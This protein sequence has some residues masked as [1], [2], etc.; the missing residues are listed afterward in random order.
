MKKSNILLSYLLAGGI[1]AGASAG[2]MGGIKIYSENNELGVYDIDVQSDEKVDIKDDQLVYANFKNAQGQTVAAF[3]NLKDP[4]TILLDPKVKSEKRRFNEVEFADW[5]ADNYNRQTPIFELKIGSMRFVNEY[6]DSLLPSE[7]I[8]YAQW[9]NKNV[10]WGPDAITL[11]H[12]ALKKGVTRSGNNL[13]LGQHATERKEVTKIEFY[14]DSFFGSF[15]IY[16]ALTG[17]GNSDDN[18]TYKIFHNPISKESLDK[19]F[20]SIPTQQVLANYDKSK[21]SAGI[22]AID[23]VENEDI[24]FYDLVK[25]LKKSFPQNK[26]IQDKLA[27]ITNEENFFVFAD[28]KQNLDQVKKKFELAILMLADEKDIQLPQ[29]LQLIFPEDFTK[30]RKIKWIRSALSPFNQQIKHDANNIPQG[31]FLLKLE[32]LM[33]ENPS[34]QPKDLQNQAQ[35]PTQTSDQRKKPQVQ[36]PNQSQAQTKDFRFSIN[37]QMKANRVALIVGELTTKIHQKAEKIAKEGFFDLYNIN[38]PVGKIIAIYQNSPEN[39]LFLPVDSKNPAL[40]AENEFITQFDASKFSTYEIKTAKKLSNYKLEIELVDQK[41]KKSIKKIIFDLDPKGKN[42]QSQ[43]EEFSSFK[44]A[45]DWKNRAIPRVIQEIETL[46]DGKSTTVYQLYAEVFDGLIDKVL[47]HRKTNGEKLVGTYIISEV[48]PKTGLKTY[49]TKQGSFI[50][51]SQSSRIP[52][53]S[54]LKASSPFFKTT[55][56]NYLKYVGAHEYGHHQTLN[57]AQ[58]IS[59]PDSSIILDAIST[60]TG[61]GLQSFYNLDVLRKYLHARSSGLDLRKAGPSLEAQKNGIYPNFTFNRDNKFESEVDIYGSNEN[62]EVDSL[63]T[64][65]SRRFLQTIDGLKTAADLRKLKLYDLF[66]LNSIDPESA[67]INP[68]I[69]DS[70]KFFRNDWQTI[71]DQSKKGFINSTESKSLFGNSLTDAAGNLLE[72][73]EKGKLIVAEFKESQ[74]KRTFSDL[75]VKVFFANGRP[76][77]D[78]TIFTKPNS[79]SELKAKIAEIQKAFSDNVV[80]NFD[81]NGWDTKAEGFSRFLPSNPFFAKSLSAILANNAEKEAFYGTKIADNPSKLEI[82]VELPSSVFD[83]SQILSIVKRYIKDEEAIKLGE[84]LVQ[85][86]KGKLDFPTFLS[87]LNKEELTNGNSSAINKLFEKI[88][89][90]PITEKKDLYI[91]LRNITYFR[92]S[93]VGKIDLAVEFIQNI[94]NI[95][96]EWL[97]NQSLGINQVLNTPKPNTTPDRKALVLKSYWNFVV[98]DQ[99]W[100]NLDKIFIIKG[101]KN[102]DKIPSRFFSAIRNFHRLTPNVYDKNFVNLTQGAVFASSHLGKLI[103]INGNEYYQN[104]KYDFLATVTSGGKNYLVLDHSEFDVKIRSLMRRWISP[105]G[106]LLK[107]DKVLLEDKNTNPKLNPFFGIA[108]D[109]KFKIGPDQKIDTSKIYLDAWD[110]TLF[111]FDYN[112]NYFGFQNEQKETVF[113]SIS[114]FIEFISID[115][116][117]LRVTKNGED[118]IRNWSLD[119]VNS[120]FDLYRYAFDR[121]QKEKFVL[122]SSTNNQLTWKKE[123]KS[124]EIIGK[125][126]ANFEISSEKLLENLQKY[127]NFLMEAFDKSTLNL[128]LKNSKIENKNIDPLFLSSIGFMGFKNYARKVD[129]NS[130]PATKFGKLTNLDRIKTPETTWLTFSTFLKENSLVFDNEDFV[131]DDLNN[132]NKSLVYKWILNFLEDKKIEFKDLDL[133]RLQYLVGTKTFADYTQEDGLI[134]QIQRMDVDLGLSWLRSKNLARF[135]TRADDFFSNYVY[136]FPESLTRDFVQIHYSPSTEELDNISPLFKKMTEA[137][138]GNEYFVDGIYTRKWIKNF[139]PAFDISQ[140]YAQNL[141]SRFSNFFLTSFVITR[142]NENLEKLYQNLLKAFK[143]AQSKNLYQKFNDLSS[144]QEAEIKK[145]IGSQE[146]P[147]KFIDKVLQEIENVDKISEI[148]SKIN[149]QKAD[150]FSELTIEVNR[151]MQDYQ[152]E[153]GNYKN[154]HNLNIQP[155]VGNKTWINGYINKNVL[156]NNGFFKDRFQRK[157][158]NWE[159]YDDNLESVKDPNIRITNLNGEKVDNRAEAFW[160][161]SLKTQGVG[162]RSVSGIWRDSKHDKV[163]FWGFLKSQDANKAHFL[164]LEDE[165]TGQRFY[166]QLATKGTNNIFYLKKQADLSSKWTLENEGYKSWVSAWS[167]I[168]EFKNALLRP[169]VSGIKRFRIYF[170]DQKRQEIKGLFTLG[171]TKFIAEN[172][173]NYQTA[174]TYIEK[175]AKGDYLV[176]RPQF[177]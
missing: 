132:S 121:L 137:N 47:N 130:L 22:P 75:K 98:S 18:L 170:S 40:E 25:I 136:S 66:L 79:L 138:T 37:Q 91:D 3:E 86:S 31:V 90:T 62:D 99:I 97:Q 55:G 165:S 148:S 126:L 77:I 36:Q 6:W 7:F 128:L 115:P 34:E 143:N 20:E 10:A 120:K 48:D 147:S 57:Y 117:A 2:I 122:K 93:L 150:L 152:G 139:I 154:Y 39:R 153:L 95:Y 88:F 151:I 106:N 54:L 71:E 28:P 51:Y 1:L 159:L 74:D 68:S 113:S 52:Y 109:F 65:K 94:Y 169:G 23:L 149:R 163:A 101:E 21:V 33:S 123:L 172:G 135:E 80:S 102:P 144:Q 104:P 112:N 38:H 134:K 63:L 161:Y 160:Y 76:A 12:F 103:S 41:D 111:G 89:L 177:K 17:K 133:F 157:V 173:K 175:T 81:N 27:K 56:I 46:K 142:N 124:T 107:F 60:N 4:K 5:F 156:T 84:K 61:I 168:G 167:I 85:D 87:I 114:D 145:I 155:V 125:L 58:D 72:F 11:E 176:I 119:Y 116:F 96:F 70:A 64:N 127:A 82:S 78:P 53:I 164:T 19:Y 43:L 158:L 174:P 50:G 9:F 16:S 131:N 166:I 8:K 67:T 45:I 26:E 141:I 14:P 108:Q 42:Y 110:K 32:D 92:D 83:P 24:Y 100:N 49:Q 35:K 129:E 105:L 162:Q 29:N 30:T 44:I 146:I 118:F 69:K 15:P 140:A 73:D 59:D 171:N 13:L